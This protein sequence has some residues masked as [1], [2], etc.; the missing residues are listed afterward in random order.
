MLGLP[1]TLYDREDLRINAFADNWSWASLNSAYHGLMA[2]ATKDIC[3]VA[4]WIWATSPSHEREVGQAM[5]TLVGHNAEIT[6][7]TGAKD[8][9][10]YMQYT[11]AAKLGTLKD[12]LQEGLQRLQRIKFQDWDLAVKLHVIKSSVY[13]AAFHGSEQVTIG[14]DH[15]QKFRHQVEEAILQNR[16]RTMKAVLLFQGLPMGFWDPGLFVILSAFKTARKWL[17]KQSPEHQKAFCQMVTKHKGQKG[18]SQ[19]PASTLK[20]YML[21]LGW[22]MSELSK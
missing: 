5:E 7:V 8:L 11:G 21:R 18:T 16:N 10:L 22:V 12:R 3:N 15:L 13:P 14:T 19:G 6:K 4:T 1:S 17:L 9:G 2:Q 20:S